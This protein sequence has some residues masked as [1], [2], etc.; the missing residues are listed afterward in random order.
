MDRRRR[1]GPVRAQQ[2]HHLYDGRVHRAT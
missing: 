2:R 1:A